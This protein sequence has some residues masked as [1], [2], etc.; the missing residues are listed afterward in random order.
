MIQLITTEN[1]SAAHSGNLRRGTVHRHS[2]SFVKNV[3]N[4][5]GSALTGVS[6]DE[7]FAL[8]VYFKKPVMQMVLGSF[9]SNSFF[10]NS[11]E[12][13]PEIYIRKDL[14]VH[15][16]MAL[17]TVYEGIFTVQEMNEY[18]MNI[19]LLIIEKSTHKIVMSGEAVT[20]SRN[21]RKSTES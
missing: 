5:P 18:S 1:N 2:F 14:L 19:E 20:F 13:L 3:Q 21:I 7:S 8:S 11:T 9:L 6:L 15:D 12:N 10:S 17:D 4:A 16:R